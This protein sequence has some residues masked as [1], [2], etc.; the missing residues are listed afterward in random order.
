MWSC[1]LRSKASLCQYRAIHIFD[2]F[3]KRVGKPWVC[4]NSTTLVAHNSVNM[5]VTSL[6]CTAMAVTSVAAH[7]DAHDVQ[8]AI[9]G[10]CLVANVVCVRLM[11]IYVYVGVYMW[12]WGYRCVCVGCERKVRVLGC[13]C[14]YTSAFIFLCLCLC[15]SCV[16]FACTCS[17]ACM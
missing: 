11:C 14:V 1:D 17:G 2:T 6:V 7:N 16:T 12:M 15:L 5:R 8:K 10:M 3:S 9:K 4:S 13:R